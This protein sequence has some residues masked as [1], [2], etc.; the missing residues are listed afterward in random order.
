MQ[1]CVQLCTALKSEQWQWCS[2][3]T[4]VLKQ[5]NNQVN[6]GFGLGSQILFVDMDFPSCGSDQWTQ[7][8]P[9]N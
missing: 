9:L 3:W 1:M 4:E 2:D 7:S 6:Y 5:D 8:D